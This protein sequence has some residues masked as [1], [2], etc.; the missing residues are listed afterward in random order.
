MN[1]SYFKGF[2]GRRQGHLVMK[3]KMKEYCYTKNIIVVILGTYFYSIDK[4]Y[5]K[6]TNDKSGITTQ[7]F[8][9]RK[10]INKPGNINKYIFSVNKY[11]IDLI[12]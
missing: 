2:E 6:V 1:K 9:N 12:R 10:I 3:K 4:L 8:R 7:V 11:N 5:Y